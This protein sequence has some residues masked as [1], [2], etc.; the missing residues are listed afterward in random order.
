MRSPLIVLSRWLVVVLPLL[1]L[2]SCRPL[3]A[4]PFCHL[5]LAGCC[6]ASHLASLLSSLCAAL[7]S[8]HSLLR[9]VVAL[10]LIVPP[11]CCPLTPPLSCHLVP[12]GYSIAYCCAT[13]SSSCRS[14]L[15]SSH[16]LLT[17]LLS[18][19]L[20]VPAGSSIT[21][22]CNTLSLSSHCVALLSSCS[23]WLLCC[24]LSC[25]PLI[26]SLCCPLILSLPFLCAALSLPHLTGWLLCCLSSHRPL[27]VLSLRRSLVV[28]RWLVVMLPLVVPP[29]HPLIVL[30]LRGPLVVSSCWLVIVSPLVVPP[31]CRPLTALPSCCLALAVFCINSHCAALSSSPCAVL[32]SSCCAPAGCCMAYIKQCRCHHQMHPSSPP[33]PPL[34]P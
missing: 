16:C 24:L 30:S 33:P 19:C 11:S 9:L 17:A 28:L 32:L 4:L 10:P 31:S 2:P 21:S 13:F 15:S 8:S 26:L 7:L 18:C 29:S 34:L 20:I 23:G 14:T 6:V 5:A 1:A 22:H 25:R 3:T 27:V 12:A